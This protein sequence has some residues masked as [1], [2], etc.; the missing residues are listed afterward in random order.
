MA[1]FAPPEPPPPPPEPQ[2]QPEPQP[3]PELEP[4]P[5]PDLEPVSLP[6]SEQP[7]SP[8]PAISADPPRPVDRVLAA[9]SG[10]GEAERSEKLL[11]LLDSAAAAGDDE[12]L[13]V[14]MELL[15]QPLRADAS[16]S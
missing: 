11:S 8:P 4:E 16:T 9:L 1:V 5:E 6:G 14:V 12:A 7:L 15:S 3:E 10:L 2:P 13:A